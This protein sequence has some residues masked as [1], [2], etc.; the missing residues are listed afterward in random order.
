MSVVPLTALLPRKLIFLVIFILIL[1][2]PAKFIYSEKQ[3][4]ETRVFL[5]VLL[6]LLVRRPSQGRLQ[7]LLMG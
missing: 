7:H 1:I 2:V 5:L 3:Q 4:T 6:K